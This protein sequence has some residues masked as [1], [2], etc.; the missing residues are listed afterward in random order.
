MINKIH[1][2]PRRIV[3]DNR[4]LGRGKVE[5][6]DSNFIP[7]REEGPVDGDVRDWLDPSPSIRSNL[8]VRVHLHIPLFSSIKF[9]GEESCSV[10]T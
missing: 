4:F 5:R 7:L 3:R 9:A 6:F 2:M 10:R 1:V 8:H